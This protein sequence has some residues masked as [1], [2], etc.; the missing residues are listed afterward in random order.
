[1]PASRLILRYPRL[2]I[3]V[4][5][6]LAIA[7]GHRAPFIPQDNSPDTFFAAD[8][9]ARH[10]YRSM[11]DTFGADE[12]ILVE[13]RGANASR[14][15][16]LLA[17]RQL[18][19]DLARAPGVKRVFSPLST[20][21]D[22]DEPLETPTPEHADQIRKELEAIPLYRTLGVY[23]PDIPSLGVAAVVVM[24]GPTSRPRLAEAIRDI[25][26]TYRDRGYQPASAGLALA[27][28]AIDKETQRSLGIFMPL[29]GLVG[30]LAGWLIFRS[31]RAI[32]AFALPA[33][34]VLLVGIGALELA[35]ESMNLVTGVM[36][37]LV[38]AVSFAGAIHLVA[39]Y[40]HARSQGHTENEAVELTLRAKLLPTTFAFLTTAVGFG[41]LA[42]SEVRAVRVLGAS[43]GFALVSALVFV[44]LGTPSL[45]KILRPRIE[46]PPH[47]TRLLAAWATW[48]IRRRLFI[49]AAA[50]IATAVSVVGVTRLESNIDGMDLLAKDAPE[51][52]HYQRLEREGLGL[53]NVD[54]WI[55]KPVPDDETLLRD[56]AKLERMAQ[57]LRGA[58]MV[59]GTIGVHDLLVLLGYRMSGHPIMPGDLDSLAMLS[60]E[61]R[62]RIRGD[63]GLY[64]HPQ[65]GLKLTLLTRTGDESVVREQ[66]ERIRAAANEAFPGAPIEISGHFT[67]LIGTPGVLTRTL[68]ESLALSAVVVLVLFFAA[69][70]SVRLVAAGMAVNLGPVLVTL[71]VMGWIGIPLDVATVMTASVIFGIA[72]DDTFHYLYHRKKSGSIVDA[73]RIAG[74]GIVG[75]TL[76]I[77]SG[78]AVLAASG[79]NPV[80]R[81]GLITAAAMAV[82]L[83]FDTFLLPALIAR[84]GVPE[85]SDQGSEGP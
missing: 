64:A 14:P 83:L 68:L 77:S 10:V 28:A 37:P 75:T 23:R 63:L 69:F 25:E 18:A 72:V 36:P 81:F 9:Q 13:L 66:H 5:T 30:L 67:M 19:D 21:A 80:V 26:T 82:A 20:R 51:R 52:I 40:A 56:A 35:G 79:F 3:L 38:L 32:A 15:E 8:E 62:Q 41:S 46:A 31:A 33:A 57:A 74:Q 54:V 65:H 70:R 84:R 6:F 4:L 22:D 50:V 29:V 55:R 71:G 1:M 39:Y 42:I 11:I 78:F 58:P 24:E 2:I 44:A 76:V 47:R 60:D 7:I 48:S 73:A 27:N 53:A 61:A 16:D 45:L 34:G 12:V 17:V 49:L 59:S 85:P 43:T